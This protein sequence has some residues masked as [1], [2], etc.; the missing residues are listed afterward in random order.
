MDLETYFKFLFKKYYRII[1]SIINK[2][3]SEKKG[4]KTI[5]YHEDKNRK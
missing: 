4:K 2:S 5:K 1:Y 3:P